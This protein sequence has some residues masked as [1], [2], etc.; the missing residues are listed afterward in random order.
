MSDSDNW[1]VAFDTGDIFFVQGYELEKW[2]E[3]KDFSDSDLAIEKRRQCASFWA[4]LKNLFHVQAIMV[5]DFHQMVRMLAKT[6]KMMRNEGTMIHGLQYIFDTVLLGEL[7]QIFTL[8]DPLG[9]NLSEE[10]LSDL[11]K[12]VYKDSEDQAFYGMRPY[13]HLCEACLER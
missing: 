3:K 8:A 2:M 4:M 9:S 10:T 1:R 6:R 12:R 7:I 5:L 11:V 13:C